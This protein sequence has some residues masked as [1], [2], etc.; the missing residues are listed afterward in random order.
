MIL[1]FVL[2]FGAVV[3]DVSGQVC[4]KLG[5]NADE[6]P[7]VRGPLGFVMALVR[8]PWIVI[9][10]AV[11]AVE[12]VI[13]YAALT[14]APLSVAFPFAALSYC[15]VVLASKFILHE[16]VSR[17]RWLATAVVAIGVALVCV[18]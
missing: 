10:V 16:Q 9:G 13:W 11:Y 5:L 17:Q 1:M 4:F 18:L 8:S 15:G 14:I 3:G 12:F 6:A 7:P 2:L